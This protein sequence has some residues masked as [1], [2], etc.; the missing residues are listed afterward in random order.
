MACVTF[1]LDSTYPEHIKNNPK[2]SLKSPIGYSI[3]PY[4]VILMIREQGEMLQMSAYLQHSAFKVTIKSLGK[5]EEM[6][7]YEVSA[8]QPGLYIWFNIE[9]L[10]IVC[11]TM[12]VKTKCAL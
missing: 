1:L 3:F 7:N 6:E 11:K 9:Y 4:I 12:F 8:C 2:L 10:L 5:R